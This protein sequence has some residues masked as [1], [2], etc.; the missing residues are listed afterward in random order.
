M[1]FAKRLSIPVSEIAACAM[2][3]Y[4]LADQHVD[5]LIPKT[6]SDLEIPSSKAILDWCW[7]NRK[8][9]ISGADK[10]AW[11]YSGAALPPTSRYQEQ[12][13]SR[14]AFDEQAK[15]SCQGY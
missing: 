4:G 10:R 8:P 9:M 3:C 7:T 1:F 14:P 13:A 5:L 15:L 6:G 12:F 2:T 11:H